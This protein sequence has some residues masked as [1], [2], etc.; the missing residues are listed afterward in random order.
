MNH[1]SMALLAVGAASGFCAPFQVPSVVVT[2]V[3]PFAG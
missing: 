3:T 1:F 2:L